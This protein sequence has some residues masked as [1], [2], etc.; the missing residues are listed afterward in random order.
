MSDFI[1]LLVLSIPFVVVGVIVGMAT[2]SL[3]RG[4]R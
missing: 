2:M 3:E 4:P 1:L